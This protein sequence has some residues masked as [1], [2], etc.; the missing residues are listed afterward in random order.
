MIP[1]EYKEDIQ[2]EESSVREL[3]DQIRSLTA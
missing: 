3:A 2:Y 1:D